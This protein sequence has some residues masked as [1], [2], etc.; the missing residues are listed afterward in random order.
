[1]VLLCQTCHGNFDDPEDAISRFFLDAATGTGEKAAE[2][3]EASDGETREDDDRRRS[4]GA[5]WVCKIANGI[6]VRGSDAS[7]REKTHVLFLSGEQVRSREF[8][9]KGIP[10]LYGHTSA[11]I[12]RVLCAWHVHEADDEDDVERFGVALLAVIDPAALKELAKC[13][14]L[15]GTEGS[16]G[17]VGGVPDEVTVTFA[18]AR[19]DAVG[20]F[21]RPAKLEFCLRNYRFHAAAEAST[22]WPDGAPVDPNAATS[23]HKRGNEERANDRRC[24]AEMAGSEGETD[25]DDA[26]AKPN[27]DEARDDE[28][29]QKAATEAKRAY[30]TMRRREAENAQTMSVA[31]AMLE[32]M[33]KKNARDL[34]ASETPVATKV[35]R[36]L[37]RMC[38]AGY[39]RDPDDPNLP[40]VKDGEAVKTLVNFHAREF[41]ELLSRGLLETMMQAWGEDEKNEDDAW[42]DSK[43]TA[44]GR[45]TETP[46]GNAVAQ[47]LAAVRASATRVSDALKRAR[48]GRREAIR[49]L[50]GLCIA[51]RQ[52]TEG[53]ETQRDD[54]DRRLAEAE[55]AL[56]LRSPLSGA[57]T[58]TRATTSERKSFHLDGDDRRGLVESNRT[59]VP[60]SGVVDAAASEAVQREKSR[61]ASETKKR[62]D[63][64]DRRDGAMYRR[65]V[66]VDDTEYGMVNDFLESRRRRLEGKTTGDDEDRD[67]EKSGT[68]TRRDKDSSTDTLKKMVQEAVRDATGRRRRSDEQGHR[69]YREDDF[70]RSRSESPVS[71]SRRRYR[72]YPRDPKRRS[73]HRRRWYYDDDDD[74]DDDDDGDDDGDV[75]VDQRPKSRWQ[76]ARRQRARENRRRQR[77]IESSGSETENDGS[78]GLCPPKRRRFR[79][80]DR[81]GGDA[82]ED[83]ARGRRSTRRSNDVR[84]S[85]KERA[86]RSKVPEGDANDD[87]NRE[88]DDGGSGADE[89]DRELAKLGGMVNRI[90]AK[91]FVDAKASSLQVARPAT[92]TPDKQTPATDKDDGRVDAPSGAHDA[93]E[94]N[95]RSGRDAEPARSESAR[96][97]RASEKTTDNGSEKGNK[98]QATTTPGATAGASV[99]PRATAVRASGVGGAFGESLQTMQ[100]GRDEQ[101]FLKRHV[102]ALTKLNLVE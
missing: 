23:V 32:E 10:V 44:D 97:E 2:A 18:G 49:K 27:A 30:E 6:P 39:I 65:L 60:A 93:G 95:A 79:Q 54:D 14:F 40:V 1:M 31:R 11:P 78:A 67:A 69:R 51:T 48:A 66:E 28:A 57:C 22:R 50:K 53:E 59:E 17:T 42:R 101:G 63:A 56:G 76:H 8:V 87:K 29:L 77:A 58:E 25:A 98:G 41:P 38:R 19:R 46:S 100:R 90:L 37:E 68:A 102:E 7:A 45:S 21:C 84:E 99:R 15:H 3:V 72:P 85:T 12:G 75:D 89:E 92:P 5:F 13:A 94:S 70:A 80:T 96:G 81:E 74:D 62:K 88:V 43:A 4:R 83:Q 86:R 61:H 20:V 24:D 52:Q 55:E 33:A 64:R 36:D 9:M 73:G 47:G 16:L 91:M 35:K 34:M 71:L 82:R 26:R